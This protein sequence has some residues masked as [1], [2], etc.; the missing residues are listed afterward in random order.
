M[1]TKI[2]RA[3]QPV[4]WWGLLVEAEV[5]DK[6]D[7]PDQRLARLYLT[8]RDEAI[9][10]EELGEDIHE[11]IYD[12][13]YRV[14]SV[15]RDEAN[16]NLMITIEPSYD[17]TTYL[18]LAHVETGLIHWKSWIKAWCFTFDDEDAFNKWAQSVV[19]SLKPKPLYVFVEVENNLVSS[20]RV[21]LDEDKAV[22]FA[23]KYTKP[24]GPAEIETY[25]TH[26]GHMI[27]LNQS[28]ANDCTNHCAIFKV[29]PEA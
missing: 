26:P 24:W 25:D 19:D 23:R 20:G 15:I 4:N 8:P 22:K 29:T 5:D 27:W 7:T 21:F 11:D 16:P 17:D 10:A 3:Q 6:D 13:F 1:S 9:P 2:A 18:Q 12:L 28:E 14:L